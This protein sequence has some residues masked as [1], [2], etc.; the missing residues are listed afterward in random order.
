M[1]YVLVSSTSSPMKP[2]SASSTSCPTCSVRISDRTRPAMFRNN[3]S[4]LSSIDMVHFLFVAQGDH[5]VDARGATC[6]D[7]ARRERH[8]D[9]QSGG[10]K[11]GKG[12]S[13]A[14]AEE[15]TF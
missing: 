10:T 1:R 9:E 2:V 11:K 5:R 13:R 12:V 4:V 14:N 3:A 8:D 15:L 7:V 6:G